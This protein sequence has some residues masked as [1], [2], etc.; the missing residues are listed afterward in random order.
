MATFVRLLGFLRDYKRGLWWS[1]ILAA[2]AMVATVTI[3]AL[4]GAARLALTV[5]RRLI[6]GRVS[7][8]VELDLRNRVYE[9]LLALELGFFDA[10]QTGQLMSRATVDLQSVLISQAILTLLFA[11]V[12]VIVI[13]PQLALVSLAPVPVVIWIAQRYGRQARPAL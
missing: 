9:H 1:G 11:S 4:T 6:A 12:A 10:Q 2:L 13:D 7:L 8:G 3:P 5:A